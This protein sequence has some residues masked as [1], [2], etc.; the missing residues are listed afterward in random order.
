MEKLTT[1][2]LSMAKQLAKDRYKWIARNADGK[3]YV[4]SNKPLKQQLEWSDVSCCAEVPVPEN[5]YSFITWAD[6][7]PTNLQKILED[8]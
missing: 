6:V 7:E 1:F 3:L 8:Q 4:F 2:E 5:D